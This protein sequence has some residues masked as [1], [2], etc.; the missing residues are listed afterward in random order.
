L[1]EPGVVLVNKYAELKEKASEIDG[2]MDKVKEAIVAYAR[3]EGVT[4]IRGSD[5]QT[6]IRFTEKF[7]FPG[8]Q[9]KEHRQL[10]SVIADAGKWMEVSKLDTSSL[11]RVIEDGLWDKGLIEEIM[12][13]GR[14]EESDSVYLSKLKDDN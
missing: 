1:Q 2:E 9:D 4:V 5:Y 7:K 11:I 3:S 13:Y 6:K 10:A 14:I 8:K 12:K